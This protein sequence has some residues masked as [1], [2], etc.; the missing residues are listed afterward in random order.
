MNETIRRKEKN[1]NVSREDFMEYIRY[2]EL[3]TKMKQAGGISESDY[4]YLKKCFMKE[5]KVVSNYSVGRSQQ[6]PRNQMGA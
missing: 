1:A 4:D 6:S 2:L 5:Y 3:L